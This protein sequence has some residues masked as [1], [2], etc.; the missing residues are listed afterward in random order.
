MDENENFEE[1][2]N[3]N[4]ENKNLFILLCSFPKDETT[5]DF[6]LINISVPL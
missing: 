2:L 3:L 6:R 5:P 1:L 4:L